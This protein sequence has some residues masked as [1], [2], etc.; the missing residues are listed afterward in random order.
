MLYFSYMETTA[1]VRRRRHSSE[2]TSDT[3]IRKI[4]T[5][6]GI[7]P[8]ELHPPLHDVIDPDALNAIFT[9]RPDGTPRTAGQVTFRWDQY[10]VTVHSDGEIR[11]EE[12]KGPDSTSKSDD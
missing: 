12:W 2:T 11:V 4:A 3:V 5:A 7:D 9:P 1:T 6:D 8:V 10:H